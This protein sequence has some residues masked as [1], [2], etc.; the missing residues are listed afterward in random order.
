MQVFLVEYFTDKEV[1]VI[2]GEATQDACL[3]HIAYNMDDALDWAVSHR[4]WGDEYP[5]WH[6]CITPR[7]VGADNCFGIGEHFTRDGLPCKNSGVIADLPL[8]PKEEE[9]YVYKKCIDPWD[10]DEEK[11]KKG[12]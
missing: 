6:W 9:E 3:A 12:T 11:P 4:G 5:A 8:A 7:E 10:E 2:C 1:G